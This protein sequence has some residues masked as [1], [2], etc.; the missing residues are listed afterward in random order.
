MKRYKKGD[1]VWVSISEEE[2]DDMAIYDAKGIATGY[3]GPVKI[4]EVLGEGL[5]TLQYQVK[6]PILYCSLNIW[7]INK[8]NIK[9]AL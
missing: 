1:M 7:A 5:G 2:A 9:Y 6:F 4:D 8:E 3:I